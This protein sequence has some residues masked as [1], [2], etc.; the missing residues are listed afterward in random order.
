MYRGRIEKRIRRRNRSPGDGGFATAPDLVRFAH[1][2]SDG[3][4]LDR[5][6]ADLLTGAKIPTRAL[7]EMSQREI[8]AVTS[9]PVSG[10]GGG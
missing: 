1:A 8:Q 3:T 7:E 6:Y 9:Q 2:L 4:V 5:P 10:G